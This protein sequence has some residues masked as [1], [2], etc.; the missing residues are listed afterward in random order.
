MQFKSVLAVGFTVASTANAVYVNFFGGEDCVNYF[1]T[2]N[3]PTGC[4]NLQSSALSWEIYGSGC[5]VTVYSGA[6]CQGALTPAQR[7]PN[8]CYDSP[9]QIKSVSATC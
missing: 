2:V 8:Q 3:V 9:V 6:N 1:Q 7:N 5:T 4:S